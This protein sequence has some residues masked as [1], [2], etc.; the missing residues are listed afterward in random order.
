MDDDTYLTHRRRPWNNSSDRK[1]KVV[2]LPIRSGTGVSVRCSGRWYRVGDLQFSGPR[3][4]QTTSEHSH[5][6]KATSDKE[7]TSA[8]LPAAFI[9]TH[10]R[11]RSRRIKPPI[12]PNTPNDRPPSEKAGHDS[13]AAHMGTQCRFCDRDP[14]P[15]K[16][17]R[18][19]NMGGEIMKE[20]RGLALAHPPEHTRSAR[21]TRRP[22]PAS[23]STHLSH[24]SEFAP[25][26]A[27]LL[28][29][30]AFGV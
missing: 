14:T 29:V 5:P 1:K 12:R 28:L 23:W 11:P 16:Y 2:I 10:R 17:L 26:D 15:G 20:N 24:W 30:A 18:T 25:S 6:H 9:L 19:R 21:R 8:K 13:R 7:S 3:L 22:A 27:L 4:P